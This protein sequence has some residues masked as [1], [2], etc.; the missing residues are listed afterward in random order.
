MRIPGGLTPRLYAGLAAT[1]TVLAASPSPVARRLRLI[2]KPLLMPALGTA[3]MWSLSGRDI[4]D[5]GL[6]RGATVAAQACSGLGD[7]ALLGKSEPA[8]LSGLG[9]FFGAHVAYTTAFVDAGRPLSD[10]EGRG[11]VVAAAATFATTAPLMGWA[12]GRKSPALRGP[13][14]AY[15]GILSSMFAASTRLDPAI[16]AS[17]RRKVVLGTGLFLASDTILGIREFVLPKQTALT[18]AAVMATYTAGQALIAS[19]VSEAVRSRAG[20]RIKGA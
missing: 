8:F 3:F 4:D 12:A 16:P 2:T 13:V 9:A 17:S 11:G 19:G 6:L 15:A 20:R 7:I 1:D 5:G 18:D 10:P 14:I